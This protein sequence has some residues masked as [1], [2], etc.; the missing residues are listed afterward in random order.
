MAIAAEGKDYIYKGEF[1]HK[2]SEHVQRY[3]GWITPDD[4]AAH[5]S[6]WDEPI[7]A[8]Y[9][10]VRLYECPPNGQGLAA[11]IAA[12]MAAGYDLGGVA[13]ADRLHLMVEIMRLA[14][15]DAQQWVCD[16]CVSDIPLAQL[17][18]PD[19]AARRRQRID[20]L[21]AARHVPYGNP[22]MGSDTVYLTAVDGEGNACSFINSLYMGTGSGLVVPGTG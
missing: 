13:A 5:N 17:A 21:R 8:D 9:R 10:G 11:I 12:N 14:F 19:H 6:T 3:G 1:A 7:S 15:A 16:P 20:P 18:H 4:M 2:L 22:L